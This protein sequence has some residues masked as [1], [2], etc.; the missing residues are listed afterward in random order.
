MR[1]NIVKTIFKKEMI[2]ILRDKKTLFMTVILPIVM[3][4]LLIILAT[5]VISTTSTSMDEKELSIAFSKAPNKQIMEKIDALTLEE[6]RLKIVEVEDYKTAINEKEIAAYVEIQSEGENESYKI[7]MNSSIDD[8]TEAT[9]RIEDLLEEYKEELVKA[10]IEEQGLDSKAILEPINYKVINIAENE[11]QVGYLLGTILPFILIIGILSGA[12]YPAIDVMAGEKERGTLETLLTMPIS[13]LELVMGKYLAV[14]LSAIVSALLSVISILLSVVFMVLSMG[15]VIEESNFSLDVTQLILPLLITFV[16][17]C[18]FTMIISAISMCICSLAKSFKEAQNATTPV[19][20]IAMILAYSSMIPNIELNST[21]ASIPVVNVVLLIKSV[22]TFRY[23]I[24]LMAIVLV[25][26]IIFVL[27][28]IWLLSKLF[29]SEEVLFGNGKGFSFLERRSNIKKGTLPSLSDGVVIYSVALLLL[30][31]VGSY[32]QVK[33]GMLGI[34]ASQILLVSIPLLVCIY[35]KTDFKRVFSL[36][37]PSIKHLF[38]G[39]CIWVGTFIFVMII[40]NVLLYWFPENEEVVTRLQEALYAKENLFFN[41][42]VI[43]L[44]PAICEEVLFRGFIFTCFKGEKAYTR[45]IIIS[46]I[47]FGLMHIDFIRLIPTTCLG[48][49]IAYAV[50]KS[51]SIFV[52]MLMHFLNNGIAVLCMHY[53]DW[54]F[55]D[56]INSSDFFSAKTQLSSV[57]LLVGLMLAFMLIGIWLLRGKKKDINKD[58]ANL[59]T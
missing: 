2:D 56:F 26:N 22:L 57:A 59:T 3:Y 33:F 38:G 9:E 47:L 7:Y 20:L 40:T 19:M 14:S 15:E 46:G 39:V 4:P 23:D 17:I 8:G 48:I 35:I 13:N 21:T 50:Y 30:I 44:T 24:S 53:P 25:S 28:S 1:I 5:Y 31:Y 37:L 18:I 16:C 51:G 58:N 54:Q 55:A 49:V 32:V 41:L 34:V 27:I 6:G 12:I 43:A 11:E 42:A 45:G 10:G 52:G 29:N 36:K